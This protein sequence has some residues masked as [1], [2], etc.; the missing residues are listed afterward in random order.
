MKTKLPYETPELEP[1]ERLSQIT[2]GDV[3]VISGSKDK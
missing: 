3:P 1:K 2:E